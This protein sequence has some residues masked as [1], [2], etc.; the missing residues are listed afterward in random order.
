MGR[1]GI[2]PAFRLQEVMARDTAAEAVQ[3]ASLK[4]WYTR[5]LGQRLGDYMHRP[6]P[7]NLNLLTDMLL[8]W[9]DAYEGNAVRVPN[10][11]DWPLT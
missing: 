10:R 6:D 4:E 7:G 3:K 2:Q 5:E 9:R 1:R 8:Q 11:P